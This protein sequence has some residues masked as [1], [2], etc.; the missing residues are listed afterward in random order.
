MKKIIHILAAVLITFSITAQVPQKM[1]YQAVIRN[2]KDSLVRNQPVN[3]RISIKQGAMDGKI[4]YQKI[5]NPMP[6]TNMNGLITVEIGAGSSLIGKFSSIDWSDGPYY[7]HTEIDPT[8]KNNYSLETTSEL[9]SVPY[10]FHA[11]TAEAISGQGLDGLIARI[12]MLEVHLNLT[13][14]DERDGTQYRM[15]TIG[16]QTWMRENLKYLPSVSGIYIWSP[17]EPHYYVNGYNGSDVDQ[18]RATDNYNTYG[19]LYN[20]TAALNGDSPVDSASIGVQGICPSGWHLPSYAEWK[21]LV[22][23]LGGDSIAGGKLKEAGTLHWLSPNTGATNESGFTALPGGG[24]ISW[25][26]Y[27]FWPP[28]N[29]S[30]LWSASWDDE[31][32]KLNSIFLDKENNN[33]NWG[34]NNTSDFKG[35]ALS[36]R[37]IKD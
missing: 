5:Y 31:I 4:V 23:Y 16:D 3:L 10:A 29:Y 21:Q 34:W 35:H 26:G 2:D 9:L 18:A 13:F 17:N 25:E 7:I 37:C 24:F 12:E 1:S 6:V 14:N 19:V 11:K 8:G 33:V 30:F 20:W 15:V 36:V 22:N 28:G 32:S 27:A